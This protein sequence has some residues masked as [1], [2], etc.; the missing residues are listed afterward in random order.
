MPCWNTHRRAPPLE[1]VI[2]YIWKEV[3]NSHP[4][5]FPGEADAT[6]PA[7]NHCASENNITRNNSFGIMRL[8]RPPRVSFPVLL[9]VCP[10]PMSVVPSAQTAATSTRPSCPLVVWNWLQTLLPRGKSSG[11]SACLS[12]SGLGRSISLC[13]RSCQGVKSCSFNPEYNTSLP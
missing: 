3:S 11:L 8:V 2:H 5:K 7:A 4:N 13:S 12:H 10:A 9:M 6:R 1:F